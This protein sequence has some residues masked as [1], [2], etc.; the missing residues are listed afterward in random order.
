M[1]YNAFEKV[2]KAFD[3]EAE[4]LGLKDIDDVV[5][6]EKRFASKERENNMRVMLDT[7]ILVSAIF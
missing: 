4:R 2:R 1:A 5:A 7:N 3:G 6:M